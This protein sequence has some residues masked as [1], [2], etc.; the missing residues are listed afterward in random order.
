MRRILFGCFVVCVSLGLLVNGAHVASAGMGGLDGSAIQAQWVMWVMAAFFAFLGRYA[1]QQDFSFVERDL[2]IELAFVSA[3]QEQGVCGIFVEV[4]NGPDF[5]DIYIPLT[6]AIEPFVGMGPDGVEREY[7]FMA[8]LPSKAN[9]M[10]QA[11]HKK[12][13]KAMAAYLQDFSSDT[14]DMAFLTGLELI[15]AK[16]AYVLAGGN[17]KALKA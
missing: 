10:A 1:G 6:L 12:A 7:V 2:A 13:F 4:D 11:Q 15:K 3:A 16:R 8:P 5:C 17:G 14:S 9:V